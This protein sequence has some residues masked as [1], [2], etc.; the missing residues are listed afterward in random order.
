MELTHTQTGR[1]LSKV[2]EA[3]LYL[4]E[5]EHDWENILKYAFNWKVDE[6]IQQYL[7]RMRQRL[8]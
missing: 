8:N 4:L 1:N 7:L 2:Q 5:A 3:I 6:W